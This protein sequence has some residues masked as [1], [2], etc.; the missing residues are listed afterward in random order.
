MGRIKSKLIKRTA[1]Q[2]KEQIDFSEN[3]NENKKFL[4]NITPS[5]KL[6]NKIAGYLTRLTRMCAKQQNIIGKIILKKKI[7]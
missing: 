6:R 7:L 2:L 5:K 4:G 3:F 1:I